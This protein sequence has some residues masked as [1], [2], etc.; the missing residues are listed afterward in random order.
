MTVEEAKKELVKRYKYLYEN[1]EFL[2]AQFLEEETEE[3]L[4]DSNKRWNSD[5]TERRIYINLNEKTLQMIEEFL[6]SHYNMESSFLYIIIEDMKREEKYQRRY[7]KA[8]TLIE[9]KKQ[10]QS[11]LMERL[12]VFNIL[13]KYGRYLEEQSGDLENKQKKLHMLDEY[14]RLARYKNDGKIYTSGKDL[15]LHDCPSGV[16]IELHKREPYRE[17][18]DVGIVK[19]DFITTIVNAP[20][21]EYNW[22][23]FT[24]EEKQEVYL[25]YHDELPHYMFIACELEEEYIQTMIDSRLIRPEHTKPCHEAFKIDESQIFVNPNDSLYRY[26][27]LCPHCGYIVNIPKEVLSEGVKQRIEKRCE[28]DKNLFR[29]NILK[30]ELIALENEGPKKTLK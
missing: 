2:L 11:P 14:F 10:T 30:S 24:E 23:I 18:S 25:Q 1:A 12:E 21:H 20:Y 9:K 4:K 19:N 27:Q 16:S 6:F 28:Q 29:K 17:K 7:E 15:T 13:C 22:S 26:Y 3:E 8:L 5:R